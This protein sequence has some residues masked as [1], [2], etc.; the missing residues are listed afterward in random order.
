MGGD[1]R[2]VRLLGG[3]HLAVVGVG[4]GGAGQLGEPPPARR[5]GVGQGDDLRPLHAHERLVETVTVVSL[6]GVA[7]DHN[8]FAHRSSLMQIVHQGLHA[9][10]LREAALAG[11]L[12]R[13][14]GDGVWN[15]WREWQGLFLRNPGQ[16]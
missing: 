3:Q 10:E 14:N 15:Q 4:G 6:P 8:A 16:Q 11:F 12:H 1:H 7:D 2:D 5:V 13:L 9:V